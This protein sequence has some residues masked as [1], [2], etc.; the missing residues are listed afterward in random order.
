MRA[1]ICRLEEYTDRTDGLMFKLVG[2]YSADM[3]DQVF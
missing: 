1:I 2:F 3:R